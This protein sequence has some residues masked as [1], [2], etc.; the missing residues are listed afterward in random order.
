MVNAIR[1]KT[2]SSVKGVML[3][4]KKNLQ[5]SPEEVKTLVRETFSAANHNALQEKMAIRYSIKICKS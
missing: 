1:A 5:V 2:I 3:I 4:F